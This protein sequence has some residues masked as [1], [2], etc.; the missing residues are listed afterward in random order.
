MPVARVASPSRQNPRKNPLSDCQFS[1]PDRSPISRTDV[2][3][4]GF[5]L[6]AIVR[7]ALARPSL[8]VSASASTRKSDARG[9]VFGTSVSYVSPARHS[10]RGAMRSPANRTLARPRDATDGVALARG[11]KSSS[12]LPNVCSIRRAAV[13]EGSTHRALTARVAEARPHPSGRETESAE[14]KWRRRRPRTT[15]A[16]RTSSGPAGEVTAS[17]EKGSAVGAHATQTKVTAVG[18]GTERLVVSRAG[19]RRAIGKHVVALR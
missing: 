16:R 6:V 7:R 18:G 15:K 1:R 12:A 5:V 17:G 3:M 11:M 4:P 10:W 13:S 14:L 19:G 9:P 8:P 2:R